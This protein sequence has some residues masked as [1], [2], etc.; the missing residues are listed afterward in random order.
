MYLNGDSKQDSS[1]DIDFEEVKKTISTFRELINK[2]NL[3]IRVG[4]RSVSENNEPVIIKP[5]KNL[6]IVGGYRFGYAIA[7][8]LAE[9]VK[10]MLKG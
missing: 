7:P 8:Y 5:F 10:E 3:E 6:M 1:M 9:K 4:F 2:S